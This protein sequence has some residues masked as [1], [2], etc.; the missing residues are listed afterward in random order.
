MVPDVDAIIRAKGAV[1]RK[2]IEGDPYAES[3]HIITNV[4]RHR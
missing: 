1:S 4:Q 3:D 2:I